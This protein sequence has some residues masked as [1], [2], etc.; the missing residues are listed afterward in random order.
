MLQEWVTFKC[1][2]QGTRTSAGKPKKE[3]NIDPLLTSYQLGSL[4]TQLSATQQ[5]NIFLLI[6]LSATALL[7][8]TLQI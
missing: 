3:Y 2:R 6:I 1:V 8:Q 7:K 4:P 5:K